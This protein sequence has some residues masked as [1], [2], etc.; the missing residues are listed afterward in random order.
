LRVRLYFWEVRR[1]RGLWSEDGSLRGVVDRRRRE[2]SLLGEVEVV[3]WCLAAGRL[4]SM[5]VGVLREVE[6]VAHRFD[7]LERVGTDFRRSDFC[8]FGFD[9]HLRC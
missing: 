2:G 4:D 6:E 7:G 1:G 9:I 5:L 3:V 8:S